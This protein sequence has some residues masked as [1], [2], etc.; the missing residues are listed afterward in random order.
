MSRDRQIAVLASVVGLAGLIVGIVAISQ[1][2]GA[3]DDWVRNRALPGDSTATSA[4]AS[5]SESDEREIREL[6][7]RLER[8]EERQVAESQ[9][10]TDDS[11]DESAEDREAASTDRDDS[12]LG[13]AQSAA[14][15]EA[16]DRDGVLFEYDAEDPAG[17]EAEQVV[18][19]MELDEEDEVEDE[20]PATT[21]TVPNYS[22]IPLED[23]VNGLLPLYA[24]ADDQHGTFVKRS[25][26]DHDGQLIIV[27][28]Y[29][30]GSWKDGYWIEDDEPLYAAKEIF[31]SK[32]FRLIGFCG[33]NGLGGVEVRA[34]TGVSYMGAPGWIQVLGEQ[35]LL[36]EK[37]YEE[38]T[39]HETSDPGAKTFYPS[40][41]A[42]PGRRVVVN[43]GEEDMSVE[44]RFI[45]RF[46][47]YDGLIEISR[48]IYDV[49][50]RRQ[51]A[52]K[53]AEGPSSSFGYNDAYRGCGFRVTVMGTFAHE[54]LESFQSEN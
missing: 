28:N 17:N 7:D 23:K 2:S 20:V 34:G 21:T 27:R 6:S 54:D 32:D 26:T 10:S 11:S 52:S 16:E 18:F 24:Y 22:D 8:L 40:S 1:V 14:P 51:A 39:K 15:E 29:T 19:E 37:V 35:A 43:A 53:W 49:V 4:T 41:I 25:W 9:E 47:H 36:V 13:A 3:E 38:Y 30:G 44:I 12:D 31:T 46:E 48:S 33:W 42:H 50:V 45:L 5:A